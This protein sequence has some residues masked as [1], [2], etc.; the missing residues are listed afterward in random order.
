MASVSDEGTAVRP[1]RVEIVMYEDRWGNH[2]LQVECPTT[3]RRT[4]TTVMLPEDRTPLTQSL[5][6]LMWLVHEVLP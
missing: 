1:V 3:G 2:V 4:R 5:P 6:N